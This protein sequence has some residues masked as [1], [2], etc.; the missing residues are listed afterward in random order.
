MKN[1]AT[2]KPKI[3]LLRR[4]STLLD[5]IRKWREGDGVSLLCIVPGAEDM[6]AALDLGGIEIA[7][8]ERMPFGFA[9][10]TDDPG[11]AMSFL[12]RAELAGR[13]GFAYDLL[14]RIATGLFNRQSTR[15]TVKGALDSS[16]SAN[17]SQVHMRSLT[18]GIMDLVDIYNVNYDTMVSLGLETS[19][20][21]LKRINPETDLR[22]RSTKKTQHG[23][24]SQQE[25]SWVVSISEGRVDNPILAEC[26]STSLLRAEGLP[27]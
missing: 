20:G 1:E 26:R 23:S 21:P 2:E 19:D 14:T 7:E 4:A 25:L 16:R 24:E 18:D 6:N 10:E 15:D 17:R 8:W 3:Q 22:V 5:D 13:K 12:G 9:S 11:L 27:N